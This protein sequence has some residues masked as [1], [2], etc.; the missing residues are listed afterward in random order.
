MM[1]IIYHYFIRSLFFV[2]YDPNFPLF[3]QSSRLLY[4]TKA[5]K[6]SFL[7]EQRTQSE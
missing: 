5:S 4:N 3:V 1:R 6:I 2:I 7:T